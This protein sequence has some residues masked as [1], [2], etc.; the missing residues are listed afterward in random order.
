M[1]RKP[2]STAGALRQ[3]ETQ[4]RVARALT[5]MREGHSATPAAQQVRTTLRTMRRYGGRALRQTPSGRYAAASGDRLRRR[6]RML[7]PAGLIAVDALGSRPASQIARY[8]AAVQR[9]LRTGDD[10]PLRAFRGKRVGRG[11]QSVPYVTDL[12]TLERLE[13]AGEVLFE[14]LYE[15]HT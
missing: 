12:P 7:T 2:A 5:L 10:R 6:L 3:A 11:R 4:V 13:H 1:A 15:S 8:W 9:Y 14:D